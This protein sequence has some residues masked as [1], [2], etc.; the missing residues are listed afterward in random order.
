MHRVRGHQS[1]GHRIQPGEV[2]LVGPR[3]REHPADARQHRA[4]GSRYQ[5]AHTDQATV[6][7]ANAQFLSTAGNRAV[8]AGVDLHGINLAGASFRGFPPDMESTNFNGASLQKTSFQLADLAGAQFQGAVATRASFE[9]ANLNGA[10][11][12]GSDDQPRERRLHRG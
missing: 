12:S 2:R 3:L 5:I 6:D 10:N 4:L 7:F 8:L 9:D 1:R 11:F